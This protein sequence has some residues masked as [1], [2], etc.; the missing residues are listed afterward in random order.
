MDGCSL[1]CFIWLCVMGF[2]YT[3][4]YCTIALRDPH[5][6]EPLS[7]VTL[8]RFYNGGLAALMKPRIGTK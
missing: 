7:E 1:F 8:G 2:I 5:F 3:C 4:L 6:F